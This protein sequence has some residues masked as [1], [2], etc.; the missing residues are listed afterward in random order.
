MPLLA[1]EQFCSPEDLFDDSRRDPADL[2]RWY[3]FH[4]RPRQEKS[5]ARELVLKGI[6]FYLPVV[7]RRWQSGGRVMRAFLPLFPGYVFIR[8]T[9]PDRRTALAT[10]RVVSVLEVR[11]Q[12]ELDADLR[13]LHRLIATGAAVTAEDNWTIGTKVEIKRGPLAGLQGV[14]VRVASGRRFVV[15]VNFIQRG[16]SVM[17]DDFALAE[18]D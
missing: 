17:L 10:R 9:E 5:L 3:V 11:M 16:A 14:I 8:A 6:P 1:S 2:R 12:E 18:V 4:T 13:Q 15:Q 7:S